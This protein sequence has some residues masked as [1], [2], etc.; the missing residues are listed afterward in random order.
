MAWIGL[1]L[2][3]PNKTLPKSRNM[4]MCLHGTK[5]LGSKFRKSPVPPGARIGVLA[6]EGALKI[7]YLAQASQAIEKVDSGRENPR[8]SK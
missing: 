7:F 2:Y 6:E 3:R 8:K 4:V 1:T 5:H